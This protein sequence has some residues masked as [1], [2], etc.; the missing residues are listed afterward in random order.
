[1]H[2][3][4]LPRMLTPTDM[5]D[6]NLLDIVGISEIGICAH[7]PEYVRLQRLEEYLLLRKKQILL[8]LSSPR[9]WRVRPIWQ[10]RRRESEFH[11]AVSCGLVF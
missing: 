4:R 10:N 6:P 2:G 8:T 3:Q 5:A 9:R 7:D 1:R 11:T